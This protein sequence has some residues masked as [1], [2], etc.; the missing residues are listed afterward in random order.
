MGFLNDPGPATE[1]QE[2]RLADV[3][4]AY[5]MAVYGP[6]LGPLVALALCS[7]EVPTPPAGAAGIDWP[8]E[9]ET[10]AECAAEMMRYDW[11]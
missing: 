4:V 1:A 3:I 9:L 6:D 5:C 11:P 2:E 10:A 7:P 8:A